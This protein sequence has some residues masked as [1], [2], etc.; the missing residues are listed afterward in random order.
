MLNFFSMETIAPSPAAETLAP[1]EVRTLRLDAG[2]S[3]AV[4][5]GLLWLTRS[6]DPSDHLLPAGTTFNFPRGA[7]VVVQALRS[8]ARYKRLP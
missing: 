5:D 4:T 2:A 1:G 8:E 7:L 3:L 6:G